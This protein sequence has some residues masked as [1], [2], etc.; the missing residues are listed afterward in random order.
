MVIHNYPSILL[1][2]PCI[3]KILRKFVHEFFFDVSNNQPLSQNR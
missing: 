1:I 3:M 2:A